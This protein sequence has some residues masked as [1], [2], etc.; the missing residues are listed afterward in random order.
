[1]VGHIMIGGEIEKTS[2]FRNSPSSES[3]TKLFPKVPIRV[4]WGCG[5]ASILT[6]LLRDTIGML[7]ELS[8]SDES[9]S[10]GDDWVSVISYTYE[11]VI[12]LFTTD[13]IRS[14]FVASLP[15]HQM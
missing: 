2:Q 14:I 13:V 8:W 12:E 11:D 3:G 10:K 15:P 9:S 7:I 5:L 4:K 1:M 6:Q